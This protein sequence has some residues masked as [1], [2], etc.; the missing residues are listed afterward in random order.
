MNEIK[1][2]RCYMIEVFILANKMD[3]RICSFENK[4]IKINK[5]QTILMV[6]QYG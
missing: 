4:I 2:L 3:D 5:Y 1:N 6:F